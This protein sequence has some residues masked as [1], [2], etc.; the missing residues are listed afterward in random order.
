MTPCSVKSSPAVQCNVRYIKTMHVNSFSPHELGEVAG[1]H[2][3]ASVGEVVILHLVIPSLHCLLR[4]PLPA[5]APETILTVSTRG[6]LHSC[7]LAVAFAMFGELACMCVCCRPPAAVQWSAARWASSRHSS[8]HCSLAAPCRARSLL[9]AARQSAT[10]SAILSWQPA[11][12]RG[13][14]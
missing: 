13:L 1:V 12:G 9:W 7:N 10:Q 8:L 2:G 4:P 5:P 3:E 11:Q 14:I 6:S